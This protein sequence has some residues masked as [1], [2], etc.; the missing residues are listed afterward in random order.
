LIQPASADGYFAHKGLE[1]NKTKLMEEAK[2]LKQE[3]ADIEK[4]GPEKQKASEAAAAKV[5]T[6]KD[7]KEK[8]KLQKDADAA[9]KEVDAVAAKIDRRKTR[10]E[11][12]EKPKDSTKPDDKGGEIVKLEDTIAGYKKDDKGPMTQP[13]IQIQAASISAVFAF[14]MSLLV[15]IAVQLLTLGRFRTSVPNENDGL[16]QTEH[17]ET[18][19]DFGGLDTFP[20]AASREPKAAKVPPG[21]KR[22]DVVVEGVENGGLLTAW[23]QLCQ[24]TDTPPDPEFKA[25]YPYVTTVQGNKFRLRG[26]DPKTLS[27]NIQKLFQKKLGK[28]LKVRVE[29]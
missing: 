1:G 14:V 3:I 4:T 7:D 10:I 16:D 24:P 25:V 8:E 21:G 26:G 28:P 18:G 17:G 9:K 29:E 19:F 20:T 5:E 12:I 6:A 13:W 22:F 2:K 15:A 23:S 11:A 27:A